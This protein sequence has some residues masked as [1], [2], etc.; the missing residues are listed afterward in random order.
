MILL[1][2]FNSLPRKFTIF[3]NVTLQSVVDVLH[4]GQHEEHH[5]Y[6]HLYYLDMLDVVKTMGAQI[7]AYGCQGN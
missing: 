1:T 3:W 4:W 5:F 6:N 2:N 7:Q